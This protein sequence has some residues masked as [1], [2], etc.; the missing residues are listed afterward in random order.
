MEERTMSYI[1][2][3]LKKAQKEKDT[4]YRRYREFLNGHEGEARRNGSRWRIPVILT[5]VCI[6]IAG[7]TAAYYL[8]RGTGDGEEPMRHVIAQKDAEPSRSTAQPMTPHDTS[9]TTVQPV[10]PPKQRESD[11]RQSSNEPGKTASPA[12]PPT[13]ETPMS[14]AE[15][16]L[17]S[18]GASPAAS[19]FQPPVVGEETSRQQ[20]PEPVT[21]QPVVMTPDPIQLYEQALAYQKTNNQVMAERLYA[22]VLKIDPRYVAAMNNLGVIYMSQNKYQ[23]ARQ[24]FQN[25]IS[26]DNDYVDPYYNLACIH[27]LSGNTVEGLAYLKKAISLKKDVKNWAKNDRDLNRLRY[28]SEFA[29]LMG[30]SAAVVPDAEEVYIVKKGEW[31]FD[32]VRKYYGVSDAVVPGIITVMKTL[33]PELH[34]SDVVYPGQK[35]VLPSKET[36]ETLASGESKTD[37][38]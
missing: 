7:I 29:E 20:D 18:S 3:A 27:T 22:S 36:I 14:Q 17:Q 28:T 31:I 1:N 9:S 38:K 13:A 35:L 8:Q 24:L 37:S 33:N 19:S 11:M 25:A 23:D 32:I 12:Q 34:S 10:Q 26:I 30:T 4:L 6:I 2:E 15:A 5:T 21:V 16:P